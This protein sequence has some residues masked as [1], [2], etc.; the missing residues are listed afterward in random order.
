MDCLDSA[1]YLAG[2]LIPTEEDLNS[3]GRKA[4]TS[5]KNDIQEIIDIFNGV[6]SYQPDKK[7]LFGFV[8][9]FPATLNS[10][11]IE[12]IVFNLEDIYEIFH[13]LGFNE[14]AFPNFKLPKKNKGN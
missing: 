10:S 2:Y 11:I 7:I 3:G 1:G 12:Q 5:K 4:S 8:I 9:S 6:D 13:N 14:N